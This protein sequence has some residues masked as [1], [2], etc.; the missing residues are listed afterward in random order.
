MAQAAWLRKSLLS[1]TGDLRIVN[2]PFYRVFRALFSSVENRL[3]GS[4]QDAIQNKTEG[5]GPINKGCLS[6]VRS[7]FVKIHNSCFG[8]Q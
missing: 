5:K 6:L 1:K 4:G 2:L 8:H 3:A 7:P